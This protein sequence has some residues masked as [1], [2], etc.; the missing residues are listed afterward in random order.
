M[1]RRKYLWAGA[2]GSVAVAIGIIW[3]DRT[4][5]RPPTLSAEYHIAVESVHLQIVKGQANNGFNDVSGRPLAPIDIAYSITL[6]N[7]TAYP[8]EVI[9]PRMQAQP[10][11]RRT[12]QREDGSDVFHTFYAT[13]EKFWRHVRPAQAPSVKHLD[14]EI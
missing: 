8:W 12:V 6:K 5:S 1:S 3:R 14:A 9:K 4:P 2:I 10:I 7:D 11:R 13:T